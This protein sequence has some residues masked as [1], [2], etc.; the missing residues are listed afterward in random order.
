MRGAPKGL[1][2]C[3]DGRWVH[4]WALKPLTIIQAAEYGKLDD[5][6]AADY[7]SRMQDP[8][9]IGM[10]PDAIVE[11]FYYFPLMVEAFKKF[12]ADEWVAWGARVKEGVQPV[13][14]P[15]EALIDPLCLDDG[16][17]V[18]VLDPEL[19]PIRHVGHHPGLRA[20]PGRGAGPRAAT[21]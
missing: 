5:A 20:H 1:F 21:R 18:E 11:I 13:R 6:P 15:E 8:N 19:G 16:C 3:A 2:E 17:V 4:Q 7:A 9:R 10:Q 14:A 12:T